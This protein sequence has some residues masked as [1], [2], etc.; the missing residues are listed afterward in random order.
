MSC[1]LFMSVA[2][3]ALFSQMRFHLGIVEGERAT[4]RCLLLH[5]EGFAEGLAFPYVW[6]VRNLH[7][8]DTTVREKKYESMD[9][10]ELAYQVARILHERLTPDELREL[11]KDDGYVFLFMRVGDDKNKLSQVTRF[12]FWRY[13]PGE[14]P[15]AYHGFW[16]NLS[17]DRLL[18]LET[19]I[20]EELTVPDSF[21]EFFGTSYDFAVT[22]FS[23][24]IVNPEKVRQRVEEE[25]AWSK[26]AGQEDVEG[27]QPHDNP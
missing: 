8:P 7:N 12:L 27:T 6:D 17:P 22:L 16:L 18:E 4:Y 26:T 1:V 2:P 9:T 11:A 10:E 21:Y 3:I 19:A 13:H 23:K 25:R 15:S 24:D 20:V 14:D 5:S